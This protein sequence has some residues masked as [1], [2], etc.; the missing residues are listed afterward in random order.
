MAY[1]IKELSLLVPLVR[2][3]HCSQTKIK[4]KGRW[5]RYFGVFVA[6]TSDLAAVIR[7]SF[8]TFAFMLIFCRD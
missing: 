8:K 7:L 5:G 6:K 3:F 4:N 1:L 2:Y